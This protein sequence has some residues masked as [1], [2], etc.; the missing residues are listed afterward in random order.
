MNTSSYTQS[1]TENKERT[2]GLLKSS[3]NKKAIHEVTFLMIINSL[4][5]FSP[6]SRCKTIQKLLIPGLGYKT[7]NHCRGTP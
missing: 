1:Y 5:P 4:I 6:N 3:G 7:L 2:E